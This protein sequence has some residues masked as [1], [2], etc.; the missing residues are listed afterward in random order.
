MR[1]KYR[2]RPGVPWSEAQQLWQMRPVPAPDC[3]GPKKSV[4]A[5]ES[6]RLAAEAWAQLRIYHL[7]LYPL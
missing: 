6:Y 4:C 1:R 7:R 5:N 3:W 2:S